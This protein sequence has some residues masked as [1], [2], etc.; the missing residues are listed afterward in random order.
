MNTPYESVTDAY[1]EMVSAGI[2][3]SQDIS[4]AYA[5]GLAEYNKSH[6]YT[7]G[8]NEYATKIANALSTL[9]K[10]VDNDIK[11]TIRGNDNWGYTAALSS[12]LAL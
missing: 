10:Y 4:D 9:N 11:Y 2:I 12:I 7:T 5:T 1:K 8:D 3:T 6:A